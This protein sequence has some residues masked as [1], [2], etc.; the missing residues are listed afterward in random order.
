MK[1]LVDIGHPAHVHYFRNFI[2]IMETTG[3]RFLI[4]A[5]D[6]EVT[7]S[8][9]KAY[10]IPYISRGKGGKGFWGK[11]LY[12]VKGDYIMYKEAKKFKPDLF[13]SF[14]SVYAAQVSKILKKPHIAF[15]DTE[16][17]LL[18]RKDPPLP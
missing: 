18:Q 13:L 17:A 3:H 9:L 2:K 4:I 11:L 6:K 16:H 12:L 8:L 1:I 14:A 15:N 7:F 10:D 5:R